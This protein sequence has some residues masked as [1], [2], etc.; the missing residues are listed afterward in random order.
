MVATQK[1][2]VPVDGSRLAERIVPLVE[3]LARKG[4][5][6]KVARVVSDSAVN[7]A[8]IRWR[9]LTTSKAPAVAIQ[10]A[11]KRE[12]IDLVAMTTHGRSGIRRAVFG[13]IAESAIRQSRCPLLVLPSFSTAREKRASRTVGARK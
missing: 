2:L 12:E 9:V 6:V 13:S 11:I 4:T 8:L 7:E 10:A 3:R 1:I 5:E